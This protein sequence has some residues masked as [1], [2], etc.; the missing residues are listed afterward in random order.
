MVIGNTQHRFA[1]QRNLYIILQK[2]NRITL[3]DGVRDGVSSAKFDQHYTL[4]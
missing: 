3:H 4:R 1:Y 2:T